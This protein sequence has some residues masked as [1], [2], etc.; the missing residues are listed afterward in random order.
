MDDPLSALDANVKK[1]IFK[2]VFM[3]KLAQKTRVLVTHAVDFLHL[4]DSIVCLKNGKIEF[5][6]NYDSVKEHPYLKELIKIHHGY[7]AQTVSLVAKT[8]KTQIL[9]SVN[10]DSD[11]EPIQMVDISQV[12]SDDSEDERKYS[13][14]SI[15]EENNLG[16]MKKRTFSVELGN[17]SEASKKMLGQIT[18]NENDEESRVNFSVYKRYLSYVGGAKQFIMTNLTLWCFVIFKVAGDFLVGS[19]ATA[20]DQHSRFGYYCGTYFFILVWQSIFVF[21]RVL[22]LTYY[23]FHGTKQLHEDMA[24]RVLKAPVNLYFDTT[25]LGRILN[26]FSKDLSVIESNL[27]FEI[28]TGYVNFYNL[29]SVFGVAA[30][31]VPWILLVMPFV[32]MITVWLYRHSIA[33]TK[34][35]ARI[36]S[37]T[38]SPLLSYLSETINGN[39]TIRAF[40]KQK[41]FIEQNYRLLNKN[42]LAT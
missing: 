16:Y 19:W 32:L 15:T 38:R 6:G 7:K 14:Q 4:A 11:E 8:E 23:S 34:E 28:G 12:T 5:Q 21:L 18:T 25:P 26:R 27:V 17:Q 9:T 33:A 35:T 31:V 39:S 24:D 13:D 29:L 37:V 36:E 10:D 20:E 30:F 40:G 22:S 1:R 3:R 42:I 2:L 41:M